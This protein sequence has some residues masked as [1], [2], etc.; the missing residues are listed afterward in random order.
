MSITNILILILEIGRICLYMRCLRTCIGEYRVSKRIAAVIFSVLWIFESIL[1]CS[2]P[3]LFERFAVQGDAFFYVVEILF[4]LIVSFCYRGGVIRHLLIAVFLPS[5]YWI[6]KWVIV[7]AFFSTYII[8]SFQHFIAAAVAV[9]LFCVLEIVWEKIGNSRQELERKLLEEEIRIYENQFE[10]IRQSQNN[11]RSLKHDMKHHIK[12]LT[13]MIAGGE[14]EAALDYLASMGAFME[15]SEEYIVSGNGR[16]DSILNYMISKAKNSGISVDWKIQIPEHLEIST[17][18]INV[19]ISNLFDNALNALRNVTQPTLYILMKYDRGV[20]CISTQNNYSIE[21]SVSEV[22]G[23]HGFGL[24]NIHRIAE[25]Y[26]GNLTITQTQG[27][28]H[29]SV[30]LYLTDT[31]VNIT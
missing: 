24:K 9:V 17:F 2:S 25:K 6:G 15:T 22:T 27:I 30:L 3:Y 26:H 29:A 13:D 1:R 21:N 4:L 5:I 20:L 23:E 18:D 8:D 7:F 16:I 19:V 10:V 31:D 12:M 11:I 28:F 14:K